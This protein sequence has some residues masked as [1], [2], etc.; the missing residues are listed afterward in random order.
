[1]EFAKTNCF[2]GTPL[3]EPAVLVVLG[4]LF[5]LLLWRV[6]RPPRPPRWSIVPRAK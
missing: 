5:M 6:A 4:I 1:M 3:E 2:G